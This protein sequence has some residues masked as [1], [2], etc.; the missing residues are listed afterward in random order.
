MEAK[1]LR[2][3][4]VAPDEVER[5]SLLKVHAGMVKGVARHFSRGRQDL[6]DD[7]FQVGQ[8]ALLRASD[9]FDPSFGR[10]F[11]AFART[12]IISDIRHYLRDC[13]PLVRPPR[14]LLEY[15]SRVLETQHS[16][17]QQ[18]GSADSVAIAAS[19][20]ISEHKVDAVLNLEA[21]IHGVSI[22]A[23]DEHPDREGLGYQLIDHRYQS[24]Q[25]AAEDR[26]ML[27]QALESL[28][29]LSRAVV[30][31]TFYEDLSQTEIAARLGISQMQVSRRLKKSLGELWRI[32]NTKVF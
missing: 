22:D 31:F 19:L 5:S 12:T 18:G 24:F 14:E 20:G 16:L 11:E 3:S 8:L 21:A 17:A 26:I 32:C 6:Y 1:V 30:E 29:D 9:R 4:T 10:S 23:V 28:N 27:A 15:R 13:V 7:L 2:A 25:L